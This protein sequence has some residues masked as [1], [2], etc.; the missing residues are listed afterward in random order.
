MCSESYNIFNRRKFVMTFV[1]LYMASVD[2]VPLP[3]LCFLAKNNDIRLLKLS[4]FCYFCF[5][6]DCDTKLKRYKTK[7]ITSIIQ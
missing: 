5:R 4:R 2:N 6:N 7:I 1:L 3:E